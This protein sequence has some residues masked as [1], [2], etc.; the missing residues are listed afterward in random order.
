ML[1][2]LSQ[3]KG[4]APHMN[5]AKLYLGTNVVDRLSRPLPPSEQ[6]TSS[7]GKVNRSADFPFGNVGDISSS[8]S[9][10]GGAGGGEYRRSRAETPLNELFRSS[11]SHSLVD[12]TP[13][14]RKRA[15][16]A[17]RERS[18]SGAG[19]PTLT[20]AEREERKKTFE[21]F[22]SRQSQSEMKKRRHTEAVCILRQH[23][24]FD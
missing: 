14:G 19:T 15:S 1:L 9:I 23:V 21:E 17:P 8:S 11:F 7:S 12:G 13:Y 4:V 2:L 3:V 24:L 18:G 22:M 20:A 5:S 16:S 6:P 10:A